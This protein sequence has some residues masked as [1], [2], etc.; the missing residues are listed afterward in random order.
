VALAALAAVAGWLTLRDPASFFLRGAS[1]VLAMLVVAAVATRWVK[2]SLHV[3]FAALAAT[4]LTSSGSSVGYVMIPAVPAVAW[5][6]LVLAR[7]SA[8]ELACGA[9]LGIAAGLAGMA[10]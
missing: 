3:A 9:V 2:V 4:V 10:A 6:R 7:H 8:V 1:T 5:S